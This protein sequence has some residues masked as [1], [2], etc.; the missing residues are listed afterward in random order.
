VTD[1]AVPDGR[2]LADY[3]IALRSGDPTPGGGSAAAYAVAMGAALAAMVARLTLKSAPAEI[4]D[5]LEPAAAR[6]DAL[7]DELSQSAREDEE[8]YGRYRAAVAL[9]K[10]TEDERTARRLAMQA[11]LRTAA[12]IP[13]LT[14]RR[15]LEAL[16]LTSGVAQSGTAHA[17]S[18][19]E[20]A[21]LLL[22]AGIEAC[23]LNVDVNVTLIKDSAISQ[24]LQRRAADLRHQSSQASKAIWQLLAAR[25]SP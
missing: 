24:E 22:S 9:P 16:K 8:C 4:A 6:L 25:K 14:A 3:L 19:V 12:E 18:D 15:G 11:S 5:R 17:L 21:R 2:S 20:A 7:V 10:T 13:L 1:S 23:L